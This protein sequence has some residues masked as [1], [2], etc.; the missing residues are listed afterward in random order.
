VFQIMPVFLLVGGFSNA[1]S[2]EG[3]C[4]GGTGYGRWLA[5]RSARMLRPAGAFLACAVTAV[6]VARLLDAPAD[7]VAMAEAS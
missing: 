3:A 1:A 7:V 6:V 2:W 5:G 4:R